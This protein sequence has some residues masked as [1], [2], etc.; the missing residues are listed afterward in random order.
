MQ[1]RRGDPT[2]SLAS[3][4]RAAQVP[5]RVPAQKRREN[6]MADNVVFP[7]V[8]LKRFINL[9]KEQTCLWDK[10]SQAYKQKQ[11]RHEAV[12]KLTE[13][14]QEFDPGATKVHVLRKIE[15]LR[16]CVRREYKRVQD[17]RQ[18]ATSPDQVYVPH[19]WYY[20]MFAFVFGEDGTNYKMKPGH[21]PS[22]STPN[23]VINCLHRCRLSK[24]HRT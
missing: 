7:R 10:T 24:K 12:S 8:L 21:S 22:Q 6:K 14:V 5:E 3:T 17:S 11:K 13:L 1:P 16:A 23:E 20:D 15:S 19:L 4:P 18:K 9:Y 2:R